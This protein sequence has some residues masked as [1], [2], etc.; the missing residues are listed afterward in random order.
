[1]RDNG[2]LPNDGVA[3]SPSMHR[4]PNGAATGGRTTRTWCLAAAV[5]LVSCAPSGATVDAGSLESIAVVEPAHVDATSGGRPRVVVLGDS[6]TAGLGLA[7]EEAYPAR[8]QHRLDRDGWRLDVVSAAESGGTTAGGR[9]RLEWALE[10]DVRLLIVALG[11]NDALRGLPIE[12]MRDNLET[13]V[14]EATTRGIRVVIAGM[15]APP[16]F[17]EAYTREFRRVFAEV[18]AGRELAYVPF[19]LQGVAG[20]P[21]LNQPDGIHPN[22]EGAERVAAHLWAT[23]EPLLVDLTVRPADE[24]EGAVAGR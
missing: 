17:G 12:Q 9:S 10:G 4:R 18:A 16:N 13:I 19:L 23:L 24:S 2:P 22:A 21:E 14:D 20:V 15:E 3:A 11:G 6:L 8:L 5:S 1:M 7:T